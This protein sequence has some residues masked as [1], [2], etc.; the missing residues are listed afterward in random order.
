MRACDIIRDKIDGAI[1]T[2][3]CVIQLR[4]LARLCQVCMS[5]RVCY[6]ASTGIYLPVKWPVGVLGM[7]AVLDNRKKIVLNE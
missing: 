5:L 4:L 3:K 7:Q 2:E 6:L 1:G